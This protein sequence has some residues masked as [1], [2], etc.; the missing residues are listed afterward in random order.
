[1][2]DCCTVTTVLLL[3]YEALGNDFLVALDPAGLPG[4]DEL[5]TDFVVGVCDRHRGIGADGIMVVRPACSVG[6]DRRPDVVMELRNADGSRAETS[7]NGLRCLALALVEAGATTG[8]EI[9]IGTDAGPRLVAVLEGLG[10]GSTMVRTDMGAVTVGPAE[11]APALGGAFEAR[12]VEVGNPHL[13]MMGPS[14]DG[15]D[16][17][18]IGQA[19]EGERAGGQNVEVVAPDHSGGLDLLVWERG[20]GLTQACGSGSCAAAAAARAAGL[21]GDCVPVRNPGG[22]LV[23]ELAGADPLPPTAFLSGPARRVFSVELA[24]SEIVA[25]V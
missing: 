17:S 15:V 19:L 12:H 8:P 20:A 16:I 9:L 18:R 23:V 6:G 10:A 2:G 11:L 13:V 24:P 7:G 14:L 1:M 21:V 3:K 5:D 22:T 25:L 4:G